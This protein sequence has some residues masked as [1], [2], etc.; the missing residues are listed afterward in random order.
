MKRRSNSEFR[1]HVALANGVAALLCIVFSH[2]SARSAHGQSRCDKPDR[3]AEASSSYRYLVGGAA[4]DS[5]RRVR[6][7]ELIARGI[8]D[9][10]SLRALQRNDYA[11]ISQLRQLK[12]FREL[13]ILLANAV[14]LSSLIRD[15]KPT[16]Y[17]TVRIM[18]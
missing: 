5:V 18:C 4:V 12:L 8:E 6:A 3:M 16:K 14:D 7:I 1:R 11:E 9:V 13:T 10:D 17:L 15:G 2:I